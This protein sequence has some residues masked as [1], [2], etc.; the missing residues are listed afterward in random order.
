MNNN[1]ILRALVAQK[2]S[3][4]GGKLKDYGDPM[5]RRFVESDIYLGPFPMKT[6]ITDMTLERNTFMV[7]GEDFRCGGALEYLHITHNPQF[8]VGTGIAFLGYGGHEWH[9]HPKE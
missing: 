2:E 9:I 8:E 3:Y 5:D 7:V 6:T 4:I 1:R